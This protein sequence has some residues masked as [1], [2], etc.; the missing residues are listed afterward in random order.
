MKQTDKRNVYLDS[1]WLTTFRKIFICIN[2]HSVK[3]RT[4][5]V[6]MLYGDE[7]VEVVRQF[8]ESSP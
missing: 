3:N 7:R 5:R 8:F 4:E 1:V 6:K 2:V